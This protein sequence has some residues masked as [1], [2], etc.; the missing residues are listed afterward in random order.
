[1]KDQTGFTTIRKVTVGHE[2]FGMPE[3]KIYVNF[4]GQD[5]VEVT[6]L[7]AAWDVVKENPQWELESIEQWHESRHIDDLKLM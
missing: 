3:D 2:F 1:M 4:E 6:S 5:P 7:D